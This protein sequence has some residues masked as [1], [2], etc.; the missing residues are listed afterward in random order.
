MVRKLIVA[1]ILAPG[2]AYA[3][4]S[5]KATVQ[6]CGDAYDAYY[7]PNVGNPSV[8][9]AAYYQIAGEAGMV[10]QCAALAGGF[11]KRQDFSRQIAGTH[12]DAEHYGNYVAKLLNTVCLMN[13]IRSLDP[14]SYS[15]ID[16]ASF[17]EGCKKG[18]SDDQKNDR[19][20]APVAAAAPPAVPAPAAARRGPGFD[21]TKAATAAE[22]AI[23]ADP[24]L[25]ELDGVL[26]E[27]YRFMMA[28]DIGDD[29]RAHLKASQRS[30]LAERNRCEDRECLARVYHSRIDEVCEYPVLSGV[31]PACTASAEI[32]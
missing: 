6:A 23:C 3:G 7:T 19:V 18:F 27:N 28:S 31:H 8:N 14:A 15:V 17:V 24:L 4:A 1:A 26:S 5:W 9:M 11:V 30:W 13:S 29:A 10:A 32:D 25:G 12:F 2:V 16:K 22:K 20:P 21:C